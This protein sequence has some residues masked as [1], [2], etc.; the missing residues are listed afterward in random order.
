M[1]LRVVGAGVGRTG[2]NSLKLA[3]E[4]LLGERCY[5]MLEVFQHLDHVPYWTAATHGEPVDWDQVFAGYG[6]AVDWPAAAFWPEL[7]TA[8]PDAVVLLSEREDADAWWRSASATIFDGIRREPQPGVD[9]DAWQA[10]V[11]ELVSRRFTPD[12][13]DEQAAKA[14]Y[15]R[16]NAEVRAAVPR[17]RLVEWRPGDG[18]GPLCD[19]LGMRVPDVPFPHV[20][21]TADFQAMMRGG[22]PV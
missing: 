12:V 5:H 4:T 3:L 17:E 1:T 8:Y 13:T 22:P 16:H 10:M 18:W 20:N 7:S 6:A 2:T 11:R 19:A 15:D 14:A 21:T 9:L